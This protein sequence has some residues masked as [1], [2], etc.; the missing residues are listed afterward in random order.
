[1]PAPAQ[2]RLDARELTRPQMRMQDAE[3]LRETTH[4]SHSER[5]SAARYST[6][7]NGRSLSIGSL[8]TGVLLVL[9]LLTGWLSSDEGHLTPQNGVGYL[10]GI[11][12]ASMMLLL[13]IYPLRKRLKMLRSFGNISGWFRVHMML[14]LIGPAAILFHSNFK[15]GSLN[16]NMALFSMLTVAASGLIGRYFY[17]QVHLGLYGRKA[18]VREILADVEGLKHSIEGGLPLSENLLTKLDAYATAALADRGG[19]LAWSAAVVGLRLR[20][21]RQRARLK[22]EVAQA[23]ALERNGRGWTRKTMRKRATQIDR[24]LVLYFSA[25]NKAAMFAFYERL[26]SLWHVMHL[27]LFILLILTAVVHVIAVHLY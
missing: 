18:E 20:S 1:M 27:P 4:L 17:K 26:F 12:G 6:Y 10:L 8:A 2:P 5:A 13:L 11:L 23:L 7:E 24:L 14:G 21:L 9:V 16:S 15:L 19:A 25:V 3:R 22:A